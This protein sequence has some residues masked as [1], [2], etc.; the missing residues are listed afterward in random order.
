[1]ADDLDRVSLT[2]AIASLRKQIREAAE[3]ARGLGPNESRFRISG[4][5]LDLTV[6]AEDTTT[7]GGEVGWW[8][9]KAKDDVANKDVVTQKVKLTLNVGDIE[10]AGGTKTG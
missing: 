2:T 5:E 4:V 6:V 9:M 7:A 10:V 1:M 8:V 3:Q